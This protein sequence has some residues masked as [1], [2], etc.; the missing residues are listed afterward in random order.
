MLSP[1]S[2]R[3]ALVIFD[4]D[5]VLVDSEPLA[6]EVLAGLLTAAGLPCD[7]AECMRVYM[8]SSLPRVR[9]L[10]E[11]RLGRPLPERFERE[12]LDGVFAAFRARLRAVEGVHAVLERMDVPFCVASSGSHVRIRLALDVTGLRRFFPDGHVFSADD[13]THGKPAPDLFLRAAAVLGA[14]PE[15]C[16]VVED[17][18]AGVEAAR[19]AGM[20]VLGYAAR[21]PPGRLAGA[22]AVFTAMARLPRLL[23]R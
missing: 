16:V 22:D 15:R 11:E 17:S 1:P 10:A 21:T 5:G 2:V 13:V 7:V 9:S 8:G 23:A 3:P 18:A 4:N 12:Y 6:N 19:A 20:R 14:L